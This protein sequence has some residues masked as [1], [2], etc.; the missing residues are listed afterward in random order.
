MR[1]ALLVAAGTPIAGQPRNAILARALAGRV[2]AGFAGRADRVT[3]AGWK[4]KMEMQ[5]CVSER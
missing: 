1:A 2:V 3:V 5:H 4:K